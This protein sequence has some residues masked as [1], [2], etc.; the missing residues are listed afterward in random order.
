MQGREDFFSVCLGQRR[1]LGRFY[2]AGLGRLTLHA[3]LFS[4][5]T[6]HTPAHSQIGVEALMPCSSGW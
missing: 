2:S 5:N 3:A 1:F 6:S 4:Q